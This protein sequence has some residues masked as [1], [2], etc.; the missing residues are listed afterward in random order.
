MYSYKYRPTG[1][2]QQNLEG[3]ERTSTEW[4]INLQLSSTHISLIE[5]GTQ[6]TALFDSYKL[7]NYVKEFILVLKPGYLWCTD[8]CNQL[9]N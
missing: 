1:L 4:F 5:L 2:A 7:K 8:K 9:W 6:F 3:D